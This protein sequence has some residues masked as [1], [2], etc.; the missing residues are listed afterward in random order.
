MNMATALGLSAPVTAIGQ[1]RR[2]ARNWWLSYTCVLGLTFFVA[3]FAFLTAPRPLSLA[4]A[5]LLLLVVV[6]VARPAVGLWLLTF[7]AVAGDWI[8]VKWY[9]FTQGMSSARSVLFVSDSL[10]VSPFEVVLGATAGGWILSMA[11]SR[12]WSLRRGALFRPVMIF[13]LFLFM[14]LV[15]GLARGGNRYVALWEFRPIIALTVI[16]LLATNLIDG[17]EG[18]RRLWSALLAAV[19]VDSVC[20][21]A[22]YNGLSA[23]AR[24]QAEA[25][26]E[27]SAALHA[28]AFFIVMAA[29][30]VMSAR[31]SRRLLLML[32]ASPIV[33]YAFILSQR[34]SA[35]VGLLAGLMM[36]A[37]MLH[38][39]RPRAFYYITPL[40]VV[41]FSGYLAAFWNSDSSAGFPAHAVKTVVA[42]GQLNEEDEGSD[43]FRAI[44]NYNI[45][46]TIHSQPLT[47][48]GFGQQFL[49]PITNADISFA[50]FWEYRTHN[51]ILWIWMKTGV[52]GFIA[53]LYLFAAA[54]RHGTRRLMAAPTGFDSALVLTSVVFVVMYA[55]FAYVDLAWDTESMVFLGIALACIAREGLPSEA[56]RTSGDRTTASRRA[57]DRDHLSEFGHESSNRTRGSWSAP[58]MPARRHNVGVAARRGAAPRANWQSTLT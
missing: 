37:V 14:G 24:E 1:K 57:D 55:V 32:L 19:V 18:Y 17:P 25:L 11:V 50:T 3:A 21:I 23:A 8:T 10:T 45:V 31:S 26:G 4:S 51:A 5:M 36:L 42:P 41:I 56:K 2:L 7:F 49:R 48:I 58:S 39:R 43:M 46:Y 33:G 38:R 34:R 52:G 9:P 29:M 27:H 40:A 47:G 6:A 20:A 13:T 12:Q 30:G 22:Y 16:Y 15:T 53:M 54:I 35:F 44:E 28:S